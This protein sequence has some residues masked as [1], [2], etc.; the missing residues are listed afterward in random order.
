MCTRPRSVFVIA[1]PLAIASRLGVSF[2]S[3]GKFP[4]CHWGL[5][6]TELEVSEIVARWRAFYQNPNQDL[7]ESWGTV[8]ELFRTP[9]NRNLSHTIKEFNPGKATD[10]WS[11]MCL[12]QVGETTQSDRKLSQQAC[13]ITRKYP[14][15]DGLTNNCQNYVLYLLEFA[16]PGCVA[17][18]TFQIALNDLPSLFTHSITIPFV[19]YR[20]AREA[21][22]TIYSTKLGPAT[23]EAHNQVGHRIN[24]GR[25]LPQYPISNIT[26]LVVF[27]Y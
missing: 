12:T 13:K 5:L 26:V 15:Y 7:N 3:D 14:D 22:L 24:V 16:C 25:H 9:D 17:P 21:V 4:F 18:Q 2:F 1:R 20:A 11:W 8:F 27:L 6:V 10:N 23:W 19:G